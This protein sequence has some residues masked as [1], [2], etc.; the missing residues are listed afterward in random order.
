[1]AEKDRRLENLVSMPLW[2]AAAGRLEKLAE[3][4]REKEATAGTGERRIGLF[5]DAEN[6]RLGTLGK[7]IEGLLKEGE[8]RVRRAYGH[9]P[10]VLSGENAEVQ[11]M[12]GIELR[13]FP[14]LTN[15]GKNAADIAMVV[16]VMDVLARDEVDVFALVSS[17]SD[18]TPLVHHLR[19]AGKEVWGYGQVS[20]PDSLRMAC[21]R[22]EEI[23]EGPGKNGGSAEGRP[24]LAQ[25][26]RPPKTAAKKK[27]RKASPEDVLRRVVREAGEKHEGGWKSVSEIG[28]ALK[29]AGVAVKS[30]GRAK[31]SA[32]LKARDDQYEM[33]D[34]GGAAGRCVR[35]NGGKEPAS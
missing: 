21:G 2:D 5:V 33:H 27:T 22:F 26:P 34:F 30:L 35:I 7:M 3:V 15:F 32:V 29:A 9:W 6:V 28:N 14:V 31:L 17:D 4:A 18:F 1:M 16:D 23:G 8:L 13:Q 10:G 25:P 12:H 11:L 20:A 19:R 24:A